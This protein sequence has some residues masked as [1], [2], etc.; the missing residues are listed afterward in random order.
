M[1]ISKKQFRFD[2]A[3]N[4]TAM[5]RL[6]IDIKKSKYFLPPYEW[7]NDTIAKWTNEL[8]LQLINFTPG[9]RSHADYTWP[10][11]KNYRGSED[12]YESIIQYEASAVSGLNGFML[13]MHLG[14]DPQ[15]T[16]KFY[17]RLPEL[18]RTLKKKGYHFQRVDEL[19]LTD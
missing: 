9:T 12:I 8:Q 7:Y 17:K 11:L 2:L 1:L 4:Y 13:L 10:G 19:L 16:D 5:A 18:I 6:G 3:D 15:R 14:T